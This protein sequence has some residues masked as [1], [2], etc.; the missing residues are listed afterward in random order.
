[1]AVDIDVHPADES[2]RVV[3]SVVPLPFDY[4]PHRPQNLT[5]KKPCRGEDFPFVCFVLFVLGG[6]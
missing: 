2:L 1:M 5:S 3:S 4:T 6:R